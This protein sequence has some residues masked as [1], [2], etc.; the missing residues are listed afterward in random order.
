[1]NK[2]NLLTIGEMSKLTGAS[3]KSLRYYEKINL[4]KPAYVSSDSGYR[5]Y[6]LNQCYLVSLI[7]FCIEL[8][9]PLK[10]LSQFIDSRE[11]VDL[12]ALLD[13]G[14][15]AT[16]K[17]IKT[18][19]KGL[20]FMSVFENQL[21]EQDKFPVGHIYKRVLPE[22]FYNVIPYN[23]AFDDS[24]QYEMSQILIGAA[25]EYEEIEE[26]EVPEYGYLCEHSPE[27]VARYLF[28]EAPGKG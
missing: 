20:A 3:I 5:Y 8:D 9:I 28:A 11:T 2:R 25:N 21:L 6:Y 15:K 12:Y 14:K 16:H 1:M 18:L 24:N 13:Y 26:V 19:E 7:M 22:K 23:K 17:K 4:L 10:E 27:G